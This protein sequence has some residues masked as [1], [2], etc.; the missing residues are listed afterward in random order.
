MHGWIAK[1]ECD[2]DVHFPVQRNACVCS[3]QVHS[4]FSREGKKYI[5]FTL[6]VTSVPKN[7]CIYKGPCSSPFFAGIGK[8]FSLQS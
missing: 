7:T 1:K 6:T 4:G 5:A 8:L 2:M 3:I